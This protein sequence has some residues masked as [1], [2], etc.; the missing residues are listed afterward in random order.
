IERDL[1]LVPIETDGLFRL[2]NI[3]FE[4]TRY[5]LLPESY[6]ELNRLI[7]VL[8]NNPSMVIRLEGHTEVF[9][10]KKD[11]KELAENRVNSVKRY[12]VETGNIDSKRIDLKS[13]GGDRPITN[14]LTEEARA[15]NRRVEVR[16]IKK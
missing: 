15:L 5:N 7:K 16:I 12:L 13:F 6:P 3:F 8:K 2:N 14:E 1:Y 11:Q 4:R 9:G 10:K